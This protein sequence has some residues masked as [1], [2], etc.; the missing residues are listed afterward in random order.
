MGTRGERQQSSRINKGQLFHSDRNSLL[1]GASLPGPQAASPRPGT[2]RPPAHRRNRLARPSARAD[3]Y[4]V[5][6]VPAAPRPSMCRPFS[7]TARAPAC[8][9]D[10]RTASSPVQQT[11]VL[12][13]RHDRQQ[14]VEP[15][16]GLVAAAIPG[17]AQPR[18]SQVDH[19]GKPRP[20]H[21]ALPAAENGA[22]AP[23]VAR[24][25]GARRSGRRARRAASA[26]LRHRRPRIAHGERGGEQPQHPDCAAVGIAAAGGGEHALL[27]AP[28]DGAQC[29]AQL[30]VGKAAA[31]QRH[32]AK[33]RAQRPCRA[34][35]PPEVEVVV[36]A[37]PAPVDERRFRCQQRLLDQS[38]D[39]AIGQR[40]AVSR[41]SP[42]ASSRGA[43]E[44]ASMT[45]RAVIGAPT[46]SENAPA[47]GTARPTRPPDPLC[48]A[49]RAASVCA[50]R[51]ARRD[52]PGT[53]PPRARAALRALGIGAHADRA[54]RPRSPR[55]RRAAPPA[56]C[57]L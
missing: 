46:N 1:S 34:Q 40:H 29:L 44:S 28:A 22:H 26:R 37:R 30:G 38:T 19:V 18:Q 42:A 11:G 47:A 33:R 57:A 49:R 56:P 36:G 16:R 21:R 23:A 51:A 8:A 55:A 48:C 4:R 27:G 53:P 39:G 9:R 2:S 50:S 10:Q 6:G 25:F 13:A 32:R 7:R 14:R 17:A 52:P 43:A 35:Q 41:R 15:R 12:E 24:P 54:S 3:L 5:R 45:W 20:P 31:P